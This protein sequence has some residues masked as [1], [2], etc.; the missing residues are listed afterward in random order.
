MIYQFDFDLE[1]ASDPAIPLDDTLGYI[2]INL[3]HPLNFIEGSCEI[4]LRP[5]YKDN[6]QDREFAIRQIPNALEIFA[7]MQS[8]VEKLANER[9]YSNSPTQELASNRR[10]LFDIQ[11][12]IV[13]GA[14]TSPEEVLSELARFFHVG[15]EHLRENPVD[16]SKQ[17]KDSSTIEDIKTLV[18]SMKAVLDKIKIYLV[19]R[20]KPK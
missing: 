19:N 4:L 10:S 13:F 2:A 3:R 11:K 8:Q 14:A 15:V 20:S 17:D 7:D 16:V 18:I 5:E 6:I 9:G 1:Y 12:D